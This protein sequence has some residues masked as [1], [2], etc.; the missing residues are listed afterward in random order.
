MLLM[1][2]SN[3]LIIVWFMLTFNGSIVNV[4][5]FNGRIIAWLMIII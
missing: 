5:D 1:F 2:L 3:G 4:K